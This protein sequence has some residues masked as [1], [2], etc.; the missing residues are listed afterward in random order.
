MKK[1]LSI[2][3]GAISLCC[4]LS[5]QMEASDFSGTLVEKR[6]K[7]KAKAKIVMPCDSSCSEKPTCPPKKPDYPKP[8]SGSVY[9]TLVETEIS[10]YTTSIEIRVPLNQ[11]QAAEGVTFDADNDTF[12]LPKGIYTFQFQ[13][14]METEVVEGGIPYFDFEHMYLNINGDS[15]RIPLDWTMAANTEGEFNTN[16]WASFSGSRI[17]TIGA[18]NTVVKFI[19][20]RYPSG[21]LGAIRFSFKSTSRTPNNNPVRIT[22]HKIGDI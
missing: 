6:S 4:L 11:I 7:A 21:P 19:L 22:L 9:A 20:S 10:E 2:I 12:T 8:C 3:F 15:S 5:A 1:Q 16:D 17:F 18:D 13:F 14:S